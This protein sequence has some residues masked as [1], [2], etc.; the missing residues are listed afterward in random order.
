MHNMVISK[1]LDLIYAFQFRMDYALCSMD[2]W[3]MDVI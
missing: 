2:G 1:F 3:K